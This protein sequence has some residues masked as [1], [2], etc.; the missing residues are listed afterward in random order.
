M[1]LKVNAAKRADYEKRLGI[2]YGKRAANVWLLLEKIWQSVDSTNSATILFVVDGLVLTG[3][4]QDL[5]DFRDSRASICITSGVA[6]AVFTQVSL[7]ALSLPAIQ[8]AH[9]AS[10]GLW[11]ISVCYGFF[12]VTN[13]VEQQAVLSSWLDAGQIRAELTF[14]KTITGDGGGVC[15]GGDLDR[16][17]SIVSPLRCL[18]FSSMT[19][20]L[21]LAVYL[22]TVWTSGG[23][24]MPGPNDTRN[25]FICFVCCM[26][27][28]FAKSF[29]IGFI[30]G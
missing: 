14:R 24:Q 1:K 30:F 4:D 12:A 22:G 16:V 13:A 18:N 2:R 27:F 11:V 3:S 7:T 6:A 9:W 23:N 17:L 20:F 10:R 29:V 8:S 21:G 25:I 19:F 5:K 15:T 28:E 26:G